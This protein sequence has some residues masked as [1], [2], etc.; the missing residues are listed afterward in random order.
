MSHPAELVWMQDYMDT[1]N[2]LAKLDDDYSRIF[3]FLLDFA[4]W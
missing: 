2:L 3:E 4:C 1:A